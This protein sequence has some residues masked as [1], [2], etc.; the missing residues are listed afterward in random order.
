MATE[1]AIAVG[2][3]LREE[4][5]DWINASRP[6][7]SVKL[8]IHSVLGD[9]Q[10]ALENSSHFITYDGYYGGVPIKTSG[11]CANGCSI[12]PYANGYCL[13]CLWD[14]WIEE[15]WKKEEQS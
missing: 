15:E 12:A 5:N 3:S 8:L 14:R 9:V 10:N 13:S 2:A 6:S 4:R 11:D 7:M 1:Y